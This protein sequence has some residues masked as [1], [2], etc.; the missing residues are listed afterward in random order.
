MPLLSIP[1]EKYLGVNF[2]LQRVARREMLVIENLRVS[3]ADEIWCEIDNFMITSKTAP[4]KNYQ[5]FA[6]LTLQNNPSSVESYL[7]CWPSSGK[8]RFIR[9]HATLIPSVIRKSADT[10][11]GLSKLAISIG[12]QEQCS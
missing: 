2:C 4:T 12:Y 11:K 3:I 7:F 9:R 6:F 1:T 10:V 8:L 5:N